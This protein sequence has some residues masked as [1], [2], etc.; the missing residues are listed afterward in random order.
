MTKMKIEPGVTDYIAVNSPS[1]ARMMRGGRW[2]RREKEFRSGLV[3][4]GKFGGV[5]GFMIRSVLWRI[6]GKKTTRDII[7]F[8]KPSAVEIHA[9]GERERLEDVR[10]IEVRKTKQPLK[11][12]KF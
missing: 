6:P 7:K 4:L 2:Y 1:V 9:E 5:V 11:V 3:R 12:I 8:K 10:K